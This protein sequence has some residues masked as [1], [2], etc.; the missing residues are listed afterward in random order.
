MRPY[1]ACLQIQAIRLLKA[2]HQ[3]HVLHRRAGGPLAQVVQPGGQLCP[4]VP[5]HN[6]LGGGQQQG[7][8]Q[9]PEEPNPENLPPV[10]R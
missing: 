6:C 3:V 8:P 1:N 7:A 9:P 10:R 4:Q 2:Q 5:Y